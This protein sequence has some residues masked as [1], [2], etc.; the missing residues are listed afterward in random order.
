M[1]GCVGRWS[2][3]GGDGLNGGC[4]EKAEWAFWFHS[5]IVIVRVAYTTGCRI[6]D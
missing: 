4:A 6:L 2:R 1:L 3:I 5:G